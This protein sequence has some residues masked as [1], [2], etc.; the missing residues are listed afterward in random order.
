MKKNALF[1]LA[2]LPI[3]LSSC[4]A[5]RPVASDYIA[6]ISFNEDK[7]QF[8][9]LQLTDIHW[10]LLTKVDQEKKYIRGLVEITQPDMLMITGDTFL[11]ANKK[12]VI[13][14]FDFIRSLGV[15]YATTWGNHDEEGE[16]TKDF[17]NQEASRNQYVDTAT[18]HYNNLSLFRNVKDD[19]YGDANY[20][21]NINKE[22]KPFYQI[23]VLDS[24][25]SY[26]DKDAGYKYDYIRDDQVSWYREM[27]DT[28][29]M[30][31]KNVY[32]P[33]IFYFHIPLWEWAMSYASNNF[34]E[35]GD[36]LGVVKEPDLYQVPGLT[37]DICKKEDGVHMWPGLYHSK[38][39]DEA[40]NRSAQAMFCGH[41]HSNNWVTRYSDVTLGY[42]VKTGRGLY[43]YG[44]KDGD[45]YDHTGGS[46]ITIYDDKS[47][48]LEQVFLDSDSVYN[49]NNKDDYTYLSS[50]N[51]E[52][53]EVKFS[54]RENTY[55]A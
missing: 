13:D 49:G 9:I 33:S 41:D 5:K 53:K 24:H 20:C 21:I 55:E 30:N 54:V 4:N 11:I 35:K 44:K 27:A 6:N 31:N 46:L 52:S 45:S 40:K 37:D 18:D 43:Y 1:S 25:S 50:I 14:F 15:P 17:L 16:Y 7:K 42:G 22:G 12:V 34:N 3:V 39:F 26:Y 48:S 2:L 10:N 47:Y 19:I 8:S 38:L 51:I 32:V 29:A 36:V 28:T 23:Y